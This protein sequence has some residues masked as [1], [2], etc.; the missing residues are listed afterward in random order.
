MRIPFS[1]WLFICFLCPPFFSGMFFFSIFFKGED[2]LKSFFFFLLHP[3]L[4]NLYVFFS[5][6]L[7]VNGGDY[8]SDVYF[9]LFIS[10]SPL[11]F[12]QLYPTRTHVNKYTHTRL[13]NNRF[14]I[15]IYQNHSKRVKASKETDNRRENGRKRKINRIKRVRERRR[16]GREEREYRKGG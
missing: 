9:F 13:H 8:Y 7:M 4:F 12:K 1:F 6:S 16:R 14:N 3:P 2:F 10:F 15:A 11:F 5:L